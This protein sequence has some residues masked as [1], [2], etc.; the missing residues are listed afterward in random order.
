MTRLGR[1]RVVLLAAG[2]VAF[3][4]AGESAARAQAPVRAGWWSTVTPGPFAAPAPAT[5]SGELQVSAVSG[6]QFAFAAVLF[7]VPSGTPYVLRLVIAGGQGTPDVRSCPTTTP[8]WPA[9]SDQPA[10][11]APAY[12]CT[13]AVPGVLAT[14]GS[15]VTFAVSGLSGD[16]KVLSLAIVPAASTFAVDFQAPAAD[17]LTVTVPSAAS[18]GAPTPSSPPPL[19][20]AVAGGQAPASGTS[21][22]ASLPAPAPSSVPA[23]AAAPALA[24]AGP[25]SSAGSS[26]PVAVSPLSA[27][28]SAPS[29]QSTPSRRR[30]GEAIGALA[31]LAALLTWAGG[32]GVLGGRIKPLSDLSV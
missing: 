10:S 8:T 19:A 13:H 23:T 5:P 32:R 20:Q 6:V 16:Q 2:T 31:Y 15:A 11:A 9:G 7:D 17:A 30:I 24:P 12:D 25:S 4:V 29:N 1:A 22:P 3:V 26:R 28:R 14:D 21:L 27:V 18:S